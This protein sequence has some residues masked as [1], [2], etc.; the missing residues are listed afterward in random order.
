MQI[1]TIEPSP[2]IAR[3]ALCCKYVLLRVAPE[4]FPFVCLFLLKV[5][6]HISDVFPLFQNVE[7]QMLRMLCGG[8]NFLGCDVDF[9]NL[10]AWGRK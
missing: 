5:G 7:T 9:K 8:I 6:R 1:N 3:I 10:S 2:F 4:T